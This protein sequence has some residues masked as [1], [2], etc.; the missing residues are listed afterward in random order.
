[1]LSSVSTPSAQSS[2]SKPRRNEDFPDPTY[3][4]PFTLTNKGKVFKDFVDDAD[5]QETV[6][7]KD[8][9]HNTNQLTLPNFDVHSM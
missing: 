5:E 3:E 8:L 7:E 2:P 4:R 1:M 9:S 6:L